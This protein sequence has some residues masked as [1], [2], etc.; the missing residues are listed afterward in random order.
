MEKM[1]WYFSDES[2]R[3]RFDDGRKIAAIRRRI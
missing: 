2:R 3:L 1:A